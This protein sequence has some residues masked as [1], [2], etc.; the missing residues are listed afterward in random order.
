MFTS[1]IQ[2]YSFICKV[3]ESDKY[4]SSSQKEKHCG[5]LY[6]IIKNIRIIRKRMSWKPEAGSGM[7]RLQNF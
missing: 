2:N 1:S 5:I 7:C 4:E 6:M 3:T